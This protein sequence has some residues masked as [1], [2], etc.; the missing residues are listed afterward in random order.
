[1]LAAEEGL[2]VVLKIMLDTGTPKL[3]WDNPYGKALVEGAAR[4]GHEAVVYHLRTTCIV[5][6]NSDEFDNP[7]FSEA[8]A[9][10]HTSVVT[11]LLEMDKAEVESKL[12]FSRTPLTVA[13]AEGRLEVVKVLLEI[14][15]ASIE[16]EDRQGKTPLAR[17]LLEGH[18]E[19]VKVLLKTGKANIV[20]KNH[21]GLTPLDV[22][23]R[24]GDWVL[25]SCS[26]P[27][28]AKTLLLLGTVRDLKRDF[29]A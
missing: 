18:G 27:L 14:G 4:N 2:G 8:C 28:L 25:R 9:L 26:I 19:V 7:P 13:A 15:K 16:A 11:L 5:N 17:A 29:K 3:D 22:A 10:G 1:L 23:E 20:S 12:Y 24:R 6:A 21:D